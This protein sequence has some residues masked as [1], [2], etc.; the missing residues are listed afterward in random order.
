MELLVVISLKKRW[1]F[2]VESMTK[3]ENFDYDKKMIK[4]MSYDRKPSSQDKEH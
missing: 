4:K 3:N 2:S 1:I